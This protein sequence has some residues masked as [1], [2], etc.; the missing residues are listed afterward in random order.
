[1]GEVYRARDPRL[2]REVAVKVLPE[3]F[4]RDPD[5]LA[6]FEREAKPVA[7]DPDYALAYAG[8]AD[9]SAMLFMHHGSAK[10]DL[11]LTE[12]ASLKALELAPQ[13]AE[14]HASRGFA[15]SLSK[16]NDE[17]EPEFKTALAIDPRQ[18][19]ALYLF[20]R[21]RVA[22]GNLPE[23]ARLFEQALELNPEDYAVPSMLTWIYRGLGREQDAKEVA[24]R[25]IEAA[26]TYAAA[27][28]EDPRP[29]CLGAGGW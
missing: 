20:A 1:M 2:D 13:L 22:Q 10:G 11:D 7:I 15:S 3:A 5:R 24:R 26:E 8:M 16:R 9:A 21:M 23:A 14:C 27:N 28:P 19:E 25:G 4:A 12:R 6:R 29:I 18:F 17:A